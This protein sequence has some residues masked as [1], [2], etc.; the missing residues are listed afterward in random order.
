MKANKT[1][2]P[3]FNSPK[4][5]TPRV[6]WL[7]PREENREAVEK[8]NERKL[9]LEQMKLDIYNM[10]I[11]LMYDGLSHEDARSKAELALDPDNRLKPF[12]NLYK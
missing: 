9:T 11:D 4:V 1:W 7:A 3:R 12:L 6:S 5:V 2:P 10:T 8:L